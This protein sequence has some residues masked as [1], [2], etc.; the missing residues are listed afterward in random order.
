[1]TATHQID[2]IAKDIIE[3]ANAVLLAFDPLKKLGELAQG[4]EKAC[5]DYLKVFDAFVRTVLPI[6]GLKAEPPWLSKDKDATLQDIGIGGDSPFVYQ[7]AG[8]II[9]ASNNLSDGILSLKT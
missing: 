3:R 7:F 8:A 4:V 2:E 5:A 9:R 6:D 1:D